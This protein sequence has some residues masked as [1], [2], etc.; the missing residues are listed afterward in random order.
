MA[1]I[2]EQKQTMLVCTFLDGYATKFF[3]PA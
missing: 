2:C 3:N 1:S